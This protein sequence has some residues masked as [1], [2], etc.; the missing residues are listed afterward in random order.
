[1]APDFVVLDV[2]SPST[3]TPDTAC[4]TTLGDVIHRTRRELLTGRREERNRLTNDISAGAASFDVDFPLGAL[5][6]GARAAID[7]EQFYVWS[8]DGT[9]AVVEP[10]DNGSTA[11][12][13][14]AGAT[15]WVNSRQSD[16][17]ILNAVNDTLR[18]LSS[19]GAGLFR[20]GTVDLTYA[21]N[22]LG[23]DLTDVTSIN[24]ILD[25]YY[26]EPSEQNRWIR[27][28][29]RQWRFQ[30]MADLTAFPSGF[31]LTFFN[32]FGAN[33]GATI[34][35]SYKTSY[36][37][38][39]DYTDNVED[40]AGLHCEAHDLLQI[41]AAIRLSDGR[42]VERNQTMSQGEA[43]RASEVPPGSVNASPNGLRARWQQRVASE[44]SRLARQ[45]PTRIW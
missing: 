38:L 21:P 17:D 33:D 14:T 43:R 23:Y 45:F 20:V 32:R 35:V 40:V 24:G 44:A 10:A 11:A 36:S 34:R 12:N 31:G 41:G 42:E 13:H 29:Q 9:T 1:M 15:V 6:G 39:A 7:L 8:A 4:T 18:E 27:V 19:P 5:K 22:T 3:P 16:F 30:R 28:P 25:V 2:G 37:L 26:P